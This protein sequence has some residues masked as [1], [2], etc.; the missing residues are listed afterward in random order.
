M[1]TS[2]FEGEQHPLLTAKSQTTKHWPPIHLF[3]DTN[4]DLQWWEIRQEGRLGDGDTTKNISDIMLRPRKE[5]GTGQ[6]SEKHNKGDANLDLVPSYFCC[7]FTDRT[8]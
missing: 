4:L 1:K 3:R 7:I 8:Q 5:I 6:A 2:K